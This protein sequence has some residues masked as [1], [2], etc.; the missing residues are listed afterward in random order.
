MQTPKN[1]T[2]LK[3]R[4]LSVFL[5]KTWFQEYTPIQQKK[6]TRMDLQNVSQSNQL[7]RVKL[8]APSDGSV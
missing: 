4:K 6:R 7:D 5:R 2:Q 1:P 8:A 3:M